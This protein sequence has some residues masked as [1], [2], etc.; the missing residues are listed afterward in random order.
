MYIHGW[1]VWFGALD[2]L[3]EEMICIG[4]LVVIAYALPGNGVLAR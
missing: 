4:S 1:L 3:D 2:S